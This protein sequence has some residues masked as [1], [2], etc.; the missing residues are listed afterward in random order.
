MKTAE[1]T[2]GT[3]LLAL[4]LLVTSGCM[5]PPAG[6]RALRAAAG[7]RPAASASIYQTTHCVTGRGPTCLSTTRLS[8]GPSIPQVGACGEQTQNAIVTA[9]NPSHACQVRLNVWTA[10]P[11]G[12]LLRHTEACVEPLLSFRVADNNTS[13]SIGTSAKAARILQAARHP[14][15]A[16]GWDSME[17]SACNVVSP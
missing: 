10:I 1:R 4:C 3:G 6:R 9:L 13:M 2:I 11:T 5:L 16:T 8:V 15:F 7:D 17:S 14:A 12:R